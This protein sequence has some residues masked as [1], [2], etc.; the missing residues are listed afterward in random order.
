ML[1]KYFGFREIHKYLVEISFLDGLTFN[2]L[3]F[4]TICVL[5]V[6]FD[7]IVNSKIE[8]FVDRS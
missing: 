5:K 7:K 4:I 6:P 2:S 3:F 8:L 1:L